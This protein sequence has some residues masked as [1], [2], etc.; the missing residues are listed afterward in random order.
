MIFLYFLYILAENEHNQVIQSYQMS[1]F[2]LYILNTAKLCPCTNFQ[3]NRL[4]IKEMGN[5]L[6]YFSLDYHRIYAFLSYTKWHLLLSPPLWHQFVIR[7]LIYVQNLRGMKTRND[8]NSM[9]NNRNDKNASNRTSLWY[10]CIFYIFLLWMSIIKW[11][12]DIKCQFFDW[13]S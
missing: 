10:S 6:V 1:I 9:K 3:V 11:S 5:I 4:D 2:S 12:N 7:W 8:R 13:I